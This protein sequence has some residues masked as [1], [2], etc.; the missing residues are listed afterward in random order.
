MRALIVAAKSKRMKWRAVSFVPLMI[1][2]TAVV[3]QTTAT[4]T[5]PLVDPSVL[6]KAD[7]V[8]R[9]VGSEGLEEAY[10]PILY[11][12]SHA[13]NLYQLRDGNLLCV[14]FS[15]TWE[16][17]SGVGIV[18][19][20][21]RRGSD[22]W[23]STQ[24]IDRREGESFQNP[25]IFQSRDGV[26]HLY[27][28]TQ[29]AN[30]PESAATVLQLRSEDNGVTWSKPEPLFKRPG[31]YTRHPPMSLRD[32][33]WL[34]P[35]SYITSAGIGKGAEMNYPAMEI[36]HDEG[37]TWKECLFLNARGL[38]QPTTVQLAPDKFVTFFRDRASN[39]IYKSTSHDGCVWT[40]P[41]ATP[42]PNNNASVQAYALRDGHIVMV[43][44][45]SHVD[46]SG[47]KATGGLRKPLSI[48]LSMDGGTTWRYVRDIETGRVGYGEAEAKPKEPGR[49]EYS[50]PTVMQTPD[51][52]IHVA[53]TYRRQAIKEVSFPE[54]WIRRGGT[55]GIYRTVASE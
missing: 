22:R 48:A 21:L 39:W 20:R 6:A 47:A 54:S 28:T 32:G 4:P 10:L 37:K 7:G 15:G 8:V 17:D 14:W 33:T 24:L 51:G 36:S 42:L 26:L 49:E 52:R 25:V 35:I 34:L 53:F 3:A 29:P 12:S 11:P 40:E 9:S 41:R 50:Y 31:A 23:S 45:N 38:I 55:E 27:H 5:K 2:A 18:M 19:S 46:R 44:D 16:G 1:C 30:G 43:F 13:A